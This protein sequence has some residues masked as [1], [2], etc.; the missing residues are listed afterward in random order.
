MTH[1]PNLVCWPSSKKGN[2]I[3]LPVILLLIIFFFFA[4]CV[5]CYILFQN[6]VKDAVF[7]LMVLFFVLNHEKHTFCQMDAKQTVIDKLWPLKCI[8]S[9]APYLC[10]FL[11]LQKY[12]I[13]IVKSSTAAVMQDNSAFSRTPKSKNEI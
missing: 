10:L 5:F 7:T 2:Y 12:E 1:A 8:N 11:S 4:R 9:V 3:L 6:I 13:N